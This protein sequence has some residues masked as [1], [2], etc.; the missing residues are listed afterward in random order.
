[1]ELIQFI[2]ENQINNFQTLKT[3]L[4]IKPYNLKIKEDESY[5]NLFL[6]HSKEDSDFSIKLVNECNGI[7]LDK[8][9]FKV[10]YKKYQS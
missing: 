3:I 2:K 9:T 10:L 4:E 8:N 5:P 1:M 6:I 7:I